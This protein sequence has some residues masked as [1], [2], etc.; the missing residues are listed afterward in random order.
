MSTIREINSDG[1]ECVCVESTSLSVIVAPAVG[2]KI[3]SLR[4]RPS[5]HEFLWRD[6]DRPL[7]CH[8]AGTEYDPNFHGGIDEL[9]PNDLP[10]TICGINL[11]DHGEL[12]TASLDYRIEAG[13]LTVSGKLP[14]SGLEYRRTMAL[15]DD[16]PRIDLRYCITNTRDEPFPLLWKLHAA[17]R[18][19]E[20]DRIVCP[21]VKAEAPDL[22]YSRWHSSQPF[23]W[24]HVEGSRADTV[25]TKSDEMD[26]LYLY[27]LREG[28][29]GLE[30]RSTG[31]HFE[32]RFDLDVFPVCWLFASYG[33]FNNSYTAILEP[34]T[35]M[36]MSVNE[37]RRH[38]VTALLQ[39]GESLET[40]VRI[41]A[42][43]GC[44]VV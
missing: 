44:S 18:I 30:N 22:D 26:F 42:G 28:R 16:E 6:E 27:E 19:S 34:C 13:K 43:P 15:A 14:L 31:M 25:P 11:P 35:T 3:I 39:P 37:A 17:L 12:W 23:D 38:G 21:A 2:G 20:G 4:H 9:L 1:V 33:G 41:H 32:Y 10:E 24:P 36:P 7:K 29:M 40:E 5:G 8:A